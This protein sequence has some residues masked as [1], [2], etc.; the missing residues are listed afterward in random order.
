MTAICGYLKQRKLHIGQFK[1]AYNEL[2][3]YKVET[4]NRER[5]DKTEHK[6]YNEELPVKYDELM[7]LTNEM[8]TKCNE[9]EVTSTFLKETLLQ[10]F[11]NITAHVRN[12]FANIQILNQSLA[13]DKIENFV[14]KLNDSV[15]PPAPPAAKTNDPTPI[16]HRFLLY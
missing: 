6:K 9:E 14:K 5:D 12:D 10:R 7:A 2:N 13:D 11:Y 16:P 15:A 3:T 1:K 8:T 4:Y